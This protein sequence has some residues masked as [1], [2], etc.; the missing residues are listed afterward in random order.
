MSESAIPMRSLTFLAALFTISCLSA[1]TTPWPTYGW[2]ASTPEAEG[3]DSAPLEDAAAFIDVNSPY[4]YSL[5]VVRH[6]RLVFERYFHGSGPSAA[7]N[8]AS[9]QKSL[10]SVLVGIALDEG[11]LHSLDQKLHDFYPQYFLPDDDPRKLDI[12]LEHLITMTSGFDASSENYGSNSDFFRVIIQA[13]LSS[14]PGEVFRYNTGLSHLLSGILT[15]VSGMSTLSYEYSR[16][17]GPLGM[18]CWYWWQDPLGYYFGGASSWFLPRDLAKFGLLVARRGVWDGRR[19]VSQE[20]LR[21]STRPHIRSSNYA[22]HWWATTLS[23]FPIAAATGY[24]GQAV[25]ASPDL[26]LVVVMTTRSD[27]ANVPQSY[28]DETGLIMTRYILPSI[29]TQPP[30]LDPGGVVNAADYTLGLAAGSFASAFGANLGLVTAGW[31]AAMPAYGALPEGVGGVTVRIGGRPAHPS[32]ASPRQVNFLV[33]GDLPPGRYPVEIVTPRTSVI[34]EVDVT[35]LAPSLFILAV[36]EDGKRMAALQAVEPGQQLELWASGL[37]PSDPPLDPGAVL[38]HPRPLRY[39]PEVTVGGRPAEIT[40]AGLAFAG[41]WQVNIRVPEGLTPG[42][43]AVE[44]RVGPA[45][46]RSEINLEIR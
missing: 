36:R 30:A 2:T 14:A 18:T 43:A 34:Q 26:D 46:S 12:T 38:D 32:Y 27:Q 5:L 4:R 19:I 15:Q 25:Y 31:D 7:N 22:Y 45:V 37:G 11:R 16:L 3:M 8:I 44:L 29:R 20:W 28:Y 23:G 42:L 21:D 35:E 6:G 24:G 10:T 40:Y 9:I 39:Q 41:V 1:Q 33:P 13:P 17:L